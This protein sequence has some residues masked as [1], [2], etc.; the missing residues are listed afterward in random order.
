MIFRDSDRGQLSPLLGI[1]VMNRKQ[2]VFYWAN[3]AMP[4]TLITITYNALLQ[5][6]L[7]GHTTDGILLGAAPAGSI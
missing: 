1:D 7:V 2:S 3:I 5:F 6:P 4:S